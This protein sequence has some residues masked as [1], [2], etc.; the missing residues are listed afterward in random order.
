MGSGDV[1]GADGG[2]AD[3]GGGGDR[4]DEWGRGSAHEDGVNEAGAPETGMNDPGGG[5]PVVRDSAV[6]ESAVS[7]RRAASESAANE[8]GVR[9]L[10]PA[11]V[12]SLAAALDLRPTKKLGQNFVIDPNTIRRIV[13]AARLDPGQRVLEVGPGLGSLTLGLLDG[14]ARV[15]AVEIDDRLAARLPETLAE[16]APGV[17]VDVLR[18]DALTV[19][20]A[21]LAE[22]G[23]QPSALVANLPY[24]V[25][26]PVLIHLLTALPGIRTG[27][28]MVQQEVAERIAAGPGSK[29]YGVPSV[30]L[31][32]FGQW[33]LAGLVGTNVF[34]PAPNVG[35]ALLRFTARDHVPEDEVARDQLFAVVDAAFSAR[36][37]T[38]RQGLAAWAGSAASAEA[39]LRDAGIDPSARA[40]QLG[41]ADFVRLARHDV[42]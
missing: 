27:L 2:S 36:R 28:V 32:W 13:V 41:F 10:G 42:P 30:K 18:A 24:N 17:P 12:R 9:L 29:V 15:V 40:E 7:D 1:S 31:A 25:S 4:D 5:E 16:Y 35:S 14:G 6:H 21:Q 26:V 33:E 37:K 20:E 11:E 34:W 8:P 22:V 3:V 39:K 38:L 19:T 23:D